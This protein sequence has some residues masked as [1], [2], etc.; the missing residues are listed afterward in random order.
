MTR[1]TSG[2]GFLAHL[3]LQERKSQSK[4]R[5][6]K[7]VSLSEEVVH[8]GQDPFLAFPET[9]FSHIGE[10]KD[11]TPELRNQLIGFFGP[12]GALPLNTTEEVARWVQAGDMAF[13]R[14]T[15]LFATRFQAFFYRAW[16]DTRAITQFDHGEGDRFSKYIGALIGNGTPAWQNRN[17][18]VD[19][20]NTIAMSSLAMG[21]IKSPVRLQQMLQFDLHGDIHVQEHVPTWIKFEADS[22]NRLGMQGST[23]GQ[24]FIVGGRVQSVN[25]KIAVHIKTKSL[26]EYRA[27]LPG[28]HLYLRLKDIVT[29]Y[30]NQSFEVDVALSL[31]ADQMP[32]AVIGQ[33]AEL[34]WLANLTP[35]GAA[36]DPDAKTTFLPAATY[37]LLDA[38]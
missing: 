4:P 38:A 7:N 16:S 3:R 10:T 25:E 29:G 12:Y 35:A 14:F 36:N 2:I 5:I 30:L 31:P 15:D 26:A 6:G 34:G 24:D 9:D 21:R 19:D 18:T 28:G 37:Q 27:F 32:P 20:L 1:S 17:E 11:G 13:V 23:L 33:S 22:L 8:L